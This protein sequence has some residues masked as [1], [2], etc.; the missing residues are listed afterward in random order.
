MLGAPTAVQETLLTHLIAF[1]GTSHQGLCSE[2]EYL[3]HRIATW[4]PQPSL[5][6]GEE[7]SHWTL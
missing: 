7:R 5:G 2:T 6:A 3:G 1:N 4:P